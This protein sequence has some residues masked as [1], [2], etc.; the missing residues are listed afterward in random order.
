MTIKEQFDSLL[1]MDYTKKEAMKE[2]AKMRN[3]KKSDVYKVIIEDK[4]E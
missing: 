4:D 1:E 3:I 2:I